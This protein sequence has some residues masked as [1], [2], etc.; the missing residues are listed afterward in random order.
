MTTS[1]GQNT[2]FIS[3]TAIW[4]CWLS[5]KKNCMP[6]LKPTKT[7]P[8]FTKL[9]SPSTKL[10]SYISSHLPPGQSTNLLPVTV[11]RMKPSYIHTFPLALGRANMYKLRNSCSY[12]TFA[13]QLCD[14]TRSPGQLDGSAFSTHSQM[15]KPT[16]CH[17]GKI[18][19]NQIMVTKP[20]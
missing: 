20:H 1:I 19:A 18:L 14:D 15:F 6:P 12:S 11:P 13:R 5:R 4:L 8:S 9:N 17:H 7:E 16:S 3:K 10:G 2:H